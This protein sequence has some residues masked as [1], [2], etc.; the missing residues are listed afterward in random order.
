MEDGLFSSH[1]CCLYLLPHTSE[2]PQAVRVFEDILSSPADGGTHRSTNHRSLRSSVMISTNQSSVWGRH[3]ILKQ[4]GFC[5]CRQKVLLSFKVLHWCILMNSYTKQ[6]LRNF[7]GCHSEVMWFHRC[8]SL[9]RFPVQ[10]GSLCQTSGKELNSLRH[11]TSL[12]WPSC[13]S[14]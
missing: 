14:Q 3:M 7:P 10:T 12:K 2:P 9:R 5:D 1:S 6:L 13:V 4:E 11:V 8:G